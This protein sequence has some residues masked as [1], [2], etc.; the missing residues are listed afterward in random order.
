M[1][2]IERIKQF[3]TVSPELE[4]S[5]LAAMS[6]RKFK[7]GDT[8]RGGVNL[9]SFAYYIT[10][11]AARLYYLRGGKE[12]TASFSF[13]DEF[14]VI[15]RYVVRKHA[16]TVA[17]EFLEPTNVVFV[18]HL[19]MK[20]LLENSSAVADEVG[21]LFMNTALVHYCHYLEE[22][23]DVMQS[24]GAEERFRWVLQRY[25]RLTRC[26]TLTQIASFIG[27]TKETLYRIKGGKYPSAT[28]TELPGGGKR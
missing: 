26:A 16:D 18:P 19:Q 13:D 17:I 24:L 20:Y 25:P 15:S 28:H 27:V 11:G 2:P 5:I 7:K 3:A 4:Y 22:I 9:S 1:H 8:I 6:E 12:H 23:N 10:K 14:I 21:L